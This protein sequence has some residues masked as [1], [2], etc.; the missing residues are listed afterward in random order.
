MVHKHIHLQEL[1]RTMKI[2]V[3]IILYLSLP[4]SIFCQRTC[5]TGNIKL[6]A[7]DSGFI[8]KSKYFKNFGVLLQDT[9]VAFNR[10]TNY[11]IYQDKATYSEKIY[12]A[13]L[14]DSALMFEVEEYIKNKILVNSRQKQLQQYVRLYMGCM[15]D[16]A[17]TCIIVQFVK[18]SEFKQ[19]SLYMKQ[20]NLLARAN[21]DLRFAIF[22]KKKNEIN[23]L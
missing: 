22:I 16:S 2:A 3:Y 4:L 5:D 1:N 20:L 9:C 13:I 7:V 19:D 15:N 23:F 6:V 21:D 10:F 14:I 12:P 11:M 8:V 17:D 18:F